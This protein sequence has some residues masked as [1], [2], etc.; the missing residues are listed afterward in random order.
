MMSSEFQMSGKP[1]FDE[2]AVISA[3]MQVFWRHGYAAASIDQLTT[4]MG[5]SRSS[6]YK[7]FTDKEGLFQ[8]VLSAYA[9]RVLS[10]MAAV[11]GRTRRQQMEALLMDFLPKPATFPRP[12]GCM[13]VRSCAEMADLPEAGKALALQGLAQQRGIFSAIL[14]AAVQAGELAPDADLT[15]LSWHFLGVLQ[16]IMTLPQAGAGQEDLRKLVDLGLR[17]WPLA[18][19]A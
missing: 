1:Q 13:L 15:A 19:T 10:R 7:R 17:A 5:L 12:P 2:A 6:L 16:A 11:E 18:D 4:A 14:E 8:E 9:A 3:A